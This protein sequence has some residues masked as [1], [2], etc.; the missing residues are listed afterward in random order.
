VHHGL[1]STWPICLGRL[2]LGWQ[3]MMKHRG[4]RGALAT[5]ARWGTRLEGYGETVNQLEGFT[6]EG[7]H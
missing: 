2:G 7:A 5:G 1:A 4:G 6:E 3:P